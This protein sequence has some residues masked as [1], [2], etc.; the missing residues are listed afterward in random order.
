MVSRDADE[1]LLELRP[2]QH[3]RGAREPWEVGDNLS[4]LGIQ[5]YQLPVTHVGE[6]EPL[7]LRVKAL[8]IEAAWLSRERQIDQ[9]GQTRLSG[10]RPW[11]EC[12]TR[13][14]EKG[15]GD[16]QDRC[17]RELV[18]CHWRPRSRLHSRLP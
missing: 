14:P 12:K 18:P 11:G 13:T 5:D 10:F 17:R 8:I 9:L 1:D 15:H 7:G 16:E 6:I 4:G 3:S 2:R